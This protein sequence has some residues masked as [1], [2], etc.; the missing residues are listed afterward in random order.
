MLLSLMLQIAMK[1]AMRATRRAIRELREKLDSGADSTS[2]AIVSG[3]SLIAWIPA[4][5]GLEHEC[6]AVL[7]VYLHPPA[8]C[9]SRRRSP[10]PAQDAEGRGSDACPST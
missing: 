5:G 9:R 1:V 7:E 4:E 8:A 10:R 2:S 3:R 6:R